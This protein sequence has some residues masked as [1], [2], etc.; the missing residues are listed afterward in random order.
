MEEIAAA[1]SDGLDRATT[2]PPCSDAP[3][4]SSPPSS[5]THVSSMS[6]H[7]TPFSQH[8][9]TTQTLEQPIDYQQEQPQYLEQEYAEPVEQEYT[10]DS[11][12]QEYVPE[13]AEQEYAPVSAEQEYAPE[14]A[15]QQYT[16]E[17]AEQAYGAAPTEAMGYQDQQDYAQVEYAQEP[18]QQQY[19]SE[20]I[21]PE[22]SSEP[23]RPFDLQE[24]QEYLQEPVQ[25]Q[26]TEPEYS[27]VPAEQEYSSVPA[28]PEYSNVPAEPEYSSVPAEPE[29]SSV[30]A[31]PE[32]SSVPA[33]PEY[34]SVPAEPE[35]SSEPAAPEYSFAPAEPEYSS[36]P[37]EPEYSSAPAEP[38]YS[39]IPAEPEYSSVP[40]EPEYSSAPAEPEYSSAPAEP[41]YSSGPAAPEYSGIPAVHEELVPQEQEP[42]EYSR[43]ISSEVFQ[44]E[45]QQ[46]EEQYE[47]DQA[48]LE[49]KDRLK[50][51][52]YE[53]IYVGVKGPLEDDDDLVM[54]VGAPI[55]IGDRF[56]TR[57]V[58]P[59]FRD[60][61]A[62]SSSFENLY[63]A[64][65]KEAGDV[66]E[67]D[68]DEQEVDS[69]ID[70]PEKGFREDEKESRRGS[71]SPQKPSSPPHLDELTPTRSPVAKYPSPID[72]TLESG[73]DQVGQEEEK[74]PV[75][76]FL[77][78]VPGSREALERSLSYQQEVPTAPQ[79]DPTT[80]QRHF[81]IPDDALLQDTLED[82]TGVED[83]GTW[84]LAAFVLFI[85]RNFL[86]SAFGFCSNPT[87]LLPFPLLL[88][89]SLLPAPLLSVVVD[90]TS[91]LSLSLFFGVI[92]HRYSRDFF[93]FLGVV[94]LFMHLIH[95]LYNLFISCMYLNSF[96]VIFYTAS[97]FLLLLRSF[98]SSPHSPHF[99]GFNHSIVCKLYVYL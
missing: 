15:E 28:E 3:A 27:S 65:K 55:E 76:Q 83:K 33:E 23:A 78:D 37:A 9:P 96:L 4:P 94:V 13:T 35:Y 2:T 57:H 47:A 84:T 66:E 77:M 26:T 92:Q 18:E 74:Q 29:Y 5:P 25:P 97:L 16:P 62:K 11:A 53:D 56:D 39:S 72:V 90:R 88:A 41:E 30:P 60:G 64:S 46:A 98:T 1:A 31:E 61:G 91:L 40:A 89:S 12:E 87:P 85:F 75:V 10:P 95:T 70:R 68:V 43:T 58:D 17:S 24:Q 50:S 42:V 49:A 21:E 67:K 14:S 36:A 20:S 82:T 51:S 80:R 69:D 71:Q 73:L 19:S 7:I 59:Q 81:S 86:P 79:E 48:T 44:T 34:S 63:E 99:G 6:D 38:E 22:H 45:E 32:Y 8:E 93:S 52:S 54:P